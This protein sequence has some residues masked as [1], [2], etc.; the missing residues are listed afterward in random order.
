[1]KARKKPV[2]VKKLTDLGLDPA[3]FGHSK[4]KTRIASME[5][6]P[7]RKPGKIIDGGMDIAGKAK[8]LVK[9]LREE[10]G[11]I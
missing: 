6:P 9:L 10:A 3:N 4:A 8:E 2:D 11:V 7:Q 5:M 1:V